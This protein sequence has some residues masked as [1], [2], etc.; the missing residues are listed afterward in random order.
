MKVSGAAVAT[1]AVVTWLSFLATTSDAQ[2]YDFF[3]LVMQ[4]PR[5]VCNQPRSNCRAAVPRTFTIHGMWPQ[6]NR[7]GSPQNCPGRV[8]DVRSSGRVD[9][10][11][12]GAMD[13]QWPNLKRGGRDPNSQF[14]THEWNKHGTCSRMSLQNYFRRAVD[15]AASVDVLRLLR[16]NRIQPDN[17]SYRRAAIEAALNR[18]DPVVKCNDVR[19]GGRTYK[20]IH[21]I[22]F[23]VQRDG[24][25]VVSCGRR[26][27]FRS[28]GSGDIRFSR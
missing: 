3:Y 2:G 13:R 6:T 14:W 22:R 26:T 9:R 25:R 18:Y 28:C 11:T 12:L 17:R 4:W 24:N 16:S 7:G 27:Q 23:C 5:A 20:Q 10:G 8:R 1:V 19:S 21:E 15:R